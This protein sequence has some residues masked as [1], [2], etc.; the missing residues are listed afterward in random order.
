MSFRNKVELELYYYR[1]AICTQKW[2]RWHLKN[3]QSFNQSFS[4]FSEFVVYFSYRFGG[5]GFSNFRRP[6]CHVK[7][8]LTFNQS[9]SAF[10]KF[11]LIFLSDLAVVGSH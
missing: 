7:N 6:R 9:F 5:G 8:L 10:C 4:A 2:P 1:A 3:L 11:L